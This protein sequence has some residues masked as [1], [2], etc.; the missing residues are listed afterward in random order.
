MS[1]FVI[2][3][4][5]PKPGREYDLINLVRNHVPRLQ[6]LEMATPRPPVVLRNRDGVIVE[7]FEWTSVA[8]LEDAQRSDE[9]QDMWKKFN[10]VSDYKSLD[11]LPESRELFAE[12]ELL[13]LH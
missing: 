8:A 7:L 1:H 3:C 12:F 5:S 13:D 11:R 9:I 10:E 2:A 4:Y 6:E